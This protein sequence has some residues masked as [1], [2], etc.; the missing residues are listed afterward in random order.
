VTF[1]VWCDVVEPG[2]VAVGDAVE[3]L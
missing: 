1:G 2:A 3:A